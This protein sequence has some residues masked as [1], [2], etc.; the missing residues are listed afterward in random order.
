MDPYVNLAISTVQSGST[1]LGSSATPKTIILAAGDGAK[2]PGGDGTTQFD[3]TLWPSAFPTPTSAEIVRVTRVGDTLTTVTRGKAPTSALTTIAVGW[4]AMAPLSAG[5][6]DQLVTTQP[7]VSTR[8]QILPSGTADSI[9]MQNNIAVPST[10]GHW[11]LPVNSTPVR[12][13]RY[14]HLHGG[15]NFMLSPHPRNNTQTSVAD[16]LYDQLMMRFCTRSIMLTQL[17]DPADYSATR[18]GPE[19]YAPYA[20]LDPATHGDYTEMT[21]LGAG[22]AVAQFRGCPAAVPYGGTQFAGGGQGVAESTAGTI[23]YGCDE[24]PRYLTP[25]TRDKNQDLAVGFK[26]DFY[27]TPNGYDSR[28]GIY[29]ARLTSLG[30]WQVGFDAIHSGDNGAKL[31]LRNNIGINGQIVLVKKAGTTISSGTFTLTWYG[32]PPTDGKSFCGTGDTSNGSTYTGYGELTAPIPYNAT[33]AQVELALESISTIGVGGSI[34]TVNTVNSGPNTIVTGTSGTAFLTD[35]W[36]GDYVT[37]AGVDYYVSVVTS[38]TQITITGNAGT[39]TGV[40]LV[41]RNVV[42]TGGPL[43]VAAITINFC[44]LCRNTH[45]VRPLASENLLV[46]G[47]WIVV[48]RASSP[49]YA[50]PSEET[51]LIATFQHGGRKD[52]PVASYYKWISPAGVTMQEMNNLGQIIGTT[53]TQAPGD[54]STKLANTAF[55]TAAVTAGGGGAGAL[56]VRTSKATADTSMTGVNAYIDLT[57]AAGVGGAVAISLTPGTWF[58]WGMVCMTDTGAGAGLFTARITDG[59]NHYASGIYSRRPNAGEAGTISMIGVVVVGTPTTVK[60]QAATSIGTTSVAKMSL[61]TNATG[62]NA[63]QLLAFK[64]A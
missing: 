37:I 30:N 14:G 33:A 3:V 63:T 39:L 56:T 45:Y 40:N 28:M 51:K 62:N 48:G 15:M 31:Q 61:P 26:L 34:G 27:N 57:D 55:V 60:L 21:G 29:Q 17:G 18:F 4:Y 20:R 41:R 52:P 6:V 2:W 46:G 5:M 8:N 64:V 44:G 42:C 38:N 58:V 36:V 7:A 49:V 47:G 25:A 1:I 9:G 11:T 54:N 32:V 43:D 13:D 35:L 59:T 24:M 22:S 12:V 23:S 53:P 50:W 10:T 16:F 19:G